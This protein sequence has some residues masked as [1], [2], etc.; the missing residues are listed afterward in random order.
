MRDFERLVRIKS[1]DGF[2]DFEDEFSI[3]ENIPCAFY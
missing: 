2:N 1:K 3:I